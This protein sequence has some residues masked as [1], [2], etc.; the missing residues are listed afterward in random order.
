[1]LQLTSK[2]HKLGVKLLMDMALSLEIYFSN[3]DYTALN[4][5][6]LIGECSRRYSKVICNL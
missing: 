2:I 6:D 1:M 3:L 5:C 4:R